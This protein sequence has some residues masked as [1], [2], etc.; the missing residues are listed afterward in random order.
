MS[1]LNDDEGPKDWEMKDEEP[2]EH[3]RE[4]WEKEEA[5]DSPKAVCPSCKKETPAGNLA[6]QF[7]KQVQHFRVIGFRVTMSGLCQKPTS[8]SVLKNV[9]C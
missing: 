4:K 7:N 1:I 9:I 5:V 6:H 3:L 2:P 8:T